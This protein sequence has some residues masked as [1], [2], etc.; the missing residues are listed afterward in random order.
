VQRALS[1]KVLRLKIDALSF[2]E[3]RIAQE[4]VQPEQLQ[5]AEQ[6]AE[7]AWGAVEPPEVTRPQFVASPGVAIPGEQV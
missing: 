5:A 1:T 3:S 6:A 4:R 2:R 7:P